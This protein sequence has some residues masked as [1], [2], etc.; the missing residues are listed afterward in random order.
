MNVVKFVF[1]PIQENTYVVWDETK[2]CVIIDAGNVS[3]RE[4]RILADFI[5][6]Q[7]HIHA[8]HNNGGFFYFQC[9][10][11]DFQI[12]QK[13]FHVAVDIVTVDG[14]SHRGIDV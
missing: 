1:N 14:S 8:E 2:E 6:E 5:A 12:I 11:D 4:D 9:Q 7:A 13:T 3:A 10:R